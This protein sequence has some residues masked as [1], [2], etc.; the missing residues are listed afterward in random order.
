MAHSTYY[1]FIEAI[2]PPSELGMRGSEVGGWLLVAKSP[3]QL[4]DSVLGARMSLGLVVYLITAG[5]GN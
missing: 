1:S 2:V 3:N 5:I 4:L